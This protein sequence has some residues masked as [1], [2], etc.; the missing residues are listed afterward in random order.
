M[1]AMTM[2]PITMRM[3]AM[4]TAIVL[5]KSVAAMSTTASMAAAIATTTVSLRR[6]DHGKG[7]QTSKQGRNAF[8]S[9]LSLKR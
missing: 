6:Q 8:H 3:N 7:Q 9:K 5:A 2:T 4:M 1:V